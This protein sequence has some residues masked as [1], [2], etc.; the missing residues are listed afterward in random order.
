MIDIQH[1][2][3]IQWIHDQHSARNQKYNGHP[4]SFHLNMVNQIA[5][6]M[7]SEIGVWRDELSLAAH[8]HDLIEDCGLT[9]NDVKAK[10][11]VFVA[12]IVRACTNY[13]RGRNREE[14][15]PDFIYEDIRNTPG[16][17]FIKMCDRL[18]NVLYSKHAGSSMYSKYCKEMLEFL[19]KVGASKYPKFEKI[20]HESCI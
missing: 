11:G 6:Q 15:M 5:N 18:A 19:E 17:T 13:T 16:A 7:W 10:L 9:Y 14:R 8:A 4:Y 3:K 20:L 12:E 2:E 1:L